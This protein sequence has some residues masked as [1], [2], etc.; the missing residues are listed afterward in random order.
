MFYSYCLLLFSGSSILF[1]FMYWIS[2]EKIT[3]ALRKFHGEQIRVK[4]S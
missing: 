2:A 4:I 1:A 3:M